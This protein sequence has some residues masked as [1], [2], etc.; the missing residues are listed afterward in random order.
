[1]TLGPPLKPL[2]SRPK[3]STIPAPPPAPMRPAEK[4]PP[5]LTFTDGLN[6]GCGFWIA[7]AVFFGALSFGLFLL[8]ILSRLN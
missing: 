1:M 7:G 5:T 3:L 8:G 4:R 2:P 6:F